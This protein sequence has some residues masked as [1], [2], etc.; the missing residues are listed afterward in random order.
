MPYCLIAL[1]PF[2]LFAFSPFRLIALSPYRLIV[3]IAVLD[4]YLEWSADR[5]KAHSVEGI[6]SIST[7]LGAADS[8]LINQ[9]VIIFR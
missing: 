6:L 1:S 7:L 4:L 5:L 3:T 8:A 9:V 2:R